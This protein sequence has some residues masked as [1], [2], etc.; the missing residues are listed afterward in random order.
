MLARAVEDVE[1]AAIDAADAWVDAI[2][3]WICAT[4]AETSA[5]DT[6]ERSKGAVRVRAPGC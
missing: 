6:D 3:D 2:I 1:A 4:R 5:R